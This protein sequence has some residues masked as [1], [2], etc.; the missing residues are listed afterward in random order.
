MQ[1]ENKTNLDK[2]DPIEEGR[3][4]KGRFQKGKSGNP[5][6]RAKNAQKAPRVIMKDLL[7]QKLEANDYERLNNILEE[8]IR[9][10]ENGCPKARAELFNRYAG[11]PKNEE[12]EADKNFDIFIHHIKAQSQIKPDENRPEDDLI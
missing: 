8:M 5:G 7:A 3:D 1:D 2:Q 10:A 11:L 12:E 4:G 6:G 9:Q